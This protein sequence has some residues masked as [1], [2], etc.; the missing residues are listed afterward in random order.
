MKL[1]YNSKILCKFASAHRAG[2]ISKGVY[3]FARS[4]ASTPSEAAIKKVTP[5]T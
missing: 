2:C 5:I 1:G 4:I 3:S